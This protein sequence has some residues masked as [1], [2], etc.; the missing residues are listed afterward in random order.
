MDQA[1]CKLPGVLDFFYGVLVSFS[2]QSI[3]FGS[4]VC[5]LQCFCASFTLVLSVPEILAWR[6]VDGSYSIARSSLVM[7][8]GQSFVTASGMSAKSCYVYLLSDSPPHCALKFSHRFGGLYW[9]TTWR[10]LSLLSLDRA[11][12]DLSWKIAHGVLYTA[13]R[14]FSFGLNYGVS[15]FCRLAPETSEHLF[16][17]CPLGSECSLLA[18]VSYVSLFPSL[19]YSFLSSCVFWF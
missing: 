16:F 2:P 1:L 5:P 3:S 18:A 15:C 7:A 11:V 14:L 4:F 12:I 10:Q 8:S 19:S 9:S 6:A 17:S 13:V